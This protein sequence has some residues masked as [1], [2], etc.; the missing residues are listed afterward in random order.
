MTQFMLCVPDPIYILT[1]LEFRPIS[2]NDIFLASAARALFAGEYAVRVPFLAGGPSIAELFTDAH[3]VVY[4]DH[5]FKTARL[6]SVL[7]EMLRACKSFALWW[8]DDWSDLSTFDMTDAVVHEV[9]R[10][11]R[12]PVGEVYLRWQR[13]AVVSAANRPTNQ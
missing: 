10:Q 2:D 11:L 9:I 12:E 1:G 13:S 7:P 3:N 4:N 8:G 5:D 6:S